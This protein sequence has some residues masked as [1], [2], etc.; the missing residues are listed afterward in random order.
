MRVGGTTGRGSAPHPSPLPASARRGSRPRSW[1]KIA[2][3]GY[4]YLL[5]AAA[6]ALTPLAA[7]AQL[8]PPAQ[9]AI[10]A[11]VIGIN[12]YKTQRTL[13][14][15]VADARDLEKALKAGGVGDLT[16]LIDGQA[17]R[18]ATEDA[19]NRL[20]AQARAGDLV[21]VSFAGHGGQL[22][23]RVK[24]SDPDGVDEIFVLGGY[25]S[26]GP[27]T[28][29]RLLDK[30]L[31]VWLTRIEQK[32]A[33]TLFLADTCH[34]G[35]LTRNVDQRA[36]ELSYRQTNL[37]IAPL[38]DA[39]TPISTAND[40]VRQAEE[41]DRLT[42]L[43]AVD[44]W[45]KA[46]EVRI[47]GQPTMRG[48]LSYAVARAFE[49]AADRD[50]DGRTTRREL[51]EYA[52]QVVQQYAE[53]R[54][55]IY[56]EPAKRAELI[57]G[58]VFRRA[59]SAAADSSTAADEAAIPVV[60]LA[61]LNGNAASLAGVTPYAARIEVVGPAAQPDLTWDVTS[62]DVISRAGDVIAKDVRTRDIGDVV[63]RTAALAAIA[64]L[65]EARPQRIVLLPNDRHHR[66]GEMLSFVAEGVQGKSVIL[67]NLASDGTVQFLYPKRFD[68]RN[69]SA[70]ELRLSDI[71]V[72]PPFGA[73]Y[74]VAIV[75]NERLP[76]LESAIAAFDNV[77]ASGRIPALLRRHLTPSARI[78]FTGAYTI[79]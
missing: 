52:R 38:D 79:P 61:L 53:S 20:V 72:E 5:L 10:R 2:L 43:A 11:L 9:G 6:F 26:Q 17:T 14:G 25:E 21:I 69:P 27:G 40:R 39:L 1:W 12:Q 62:G 19:M 13:L 28:A 55:A 57:D 50:R 47:P 73:D 70:P 56:T 44:K 3:L 32:G 42:F 51:F 49:G 8:A 58:I 75:S 54:Q 34:G 41:F 65:S 78:G 15:A 22:P 16:V 77:R 36:G 29:E 7:Q 48:A 46:P 67:F 68:R 76:E 45:T 74:L 66:R 4:V 35:G 30:E 23:E 64:K 59:G 60:R 24:G 33:S 31:N 63:D 18:R 37:K 71:K